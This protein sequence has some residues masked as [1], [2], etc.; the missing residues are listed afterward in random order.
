MCRAMI[1]QQQWSRNVFRWP[2]NK[3]RDDIV[4]K[5]VPDLLVGNRN[6]SAADSRQFVW[7]YTE[8]VWVLVE[9]RLSSVDQSGPRHA[10]VAPSRPAR[11]SYILCARELAAS[12]VLPW[13][14]M[15]TSLIWSDR[16]RWKVNR[17]GAAAFKTD[18]G[19]GMAGRPSQ[20]SR[21]CN[22][23]A[24]AQERPSMLGM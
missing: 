9:R 12:G 6:S 22:A 13:R 24:S 19:L 2:R 11:R 3:S 15:S 4:G 17:A 16:R 18:C 10:S 5:W 1:E 21:C 23:V 14:L 20:P 8:T 7:S